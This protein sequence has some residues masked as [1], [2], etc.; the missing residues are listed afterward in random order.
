MNLRI[1]TQVT[2][3][4]AAALLFAVPAMAAVSVE[5]AAKLEAE[6][7]AA[8]CP[9]TFKVKFECS[10]GTFVAEFYKDWA[11]IGVQR[12]HDLVKDDF[13]NDA[14]FFRVLDGFM[15]QFGIAGDPAKQ[16]KWREKPL[17]VEPVTQSNT[18]GMIS[19]AMM[20]SGA[21]PKQTTNNR[22]TQMFINFGDN[23]NLDPMGF[24][25]IGKVVEGMEIVDGLYS[26]YGEGAPRGR[27]PAQD[28][29][30][31]QGNKYLQEKF[32]KLDYIK[33]ATVVTD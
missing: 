2:L 23:S 12:M 15:A 21:Q 33:T 19:Y 8:E 13:F 6:A 30:Q 32:P 20:G 18:R 9:D 24:A 31:S 29:I 14:R 11:P 7:G 10:N 26:G 1:W 16:T 25:P 5:D 22:T 4:L 28:L 27:G 17:G 3:L